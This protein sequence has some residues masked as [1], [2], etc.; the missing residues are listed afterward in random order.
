[1][2]VEIRRRSD[3]IHAQVAD[4]PEIWGCGR[5]FLSALGNLVATHKEQF[6][7]EFIDH[8][9]DGEG[10]NEEGRL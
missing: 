9:P 2:K 5:N 1:M 7:I 8:N 10:E 4:H 3:D 6:G